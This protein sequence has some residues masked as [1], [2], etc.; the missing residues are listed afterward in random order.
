MRMVAVFDHTV[1]NFNQLGE[2]ILTKHTHAEQNFTLCPKCEIFPCFYKGFFKY[3]HQYM[4]FILH[5]SRGAN[6]YP[7]LTGIFN[8]FTIK[9]KLHRI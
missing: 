8:C 6:F 5:L 2:D 3:F 7:D 4:K 1:E 9:F